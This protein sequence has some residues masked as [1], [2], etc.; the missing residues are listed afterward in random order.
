MKNLLRKEILFSTNIQVV[1][2]LIL[3]VFMVLI[4][5]WPGMVS[6]IYLIYAIIPIFP[7]NQTN[8]DTTFTALLPIEK[9]KVVDAKLLYVICFELAVILLS[10]PFSALRIYLLEPAMYASDPTAVDASMYQS[11]IPPDLICYGFVLCSCGI[12]N[13]ILIPWAYKNPV[14]STFVANITGLICLFVLGAFLGLQI[15]LEYLLIKA[16]SAALT[17]GVGFGVLAL[18]ILAFA[19]FSLLALK[20]GRKAFLSADL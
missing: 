20:K 8:Q 10:A 18:G 3:S 6:F 7:K 9:K 17:Y 11:L 16:E 5:S 4:P 15:L 1:I 2:F 14:K 19:L 13:A 12:L